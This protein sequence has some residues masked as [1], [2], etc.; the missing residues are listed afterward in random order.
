MGKGGIYGKRKKQEK[1]K[2]PREDREST[3]SGGTS[4]TRDAVE[5]YG[6]YTKTQGY[7]TALETVRKRKY[8]RKR[9]KK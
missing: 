2:S 7:D 4:S 1:P 6:T 9:G 3:G 5:R 8:E